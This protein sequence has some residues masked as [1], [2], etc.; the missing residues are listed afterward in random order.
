MSSFT[1]PPRDIN[2]Y[3]QHDRFGEFSN[4]YEARIRLKGKAWATTGEQRARRGRNR[5]EAIG[6]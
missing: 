6:G 4:F 1:P 3:S 2:F 5:P